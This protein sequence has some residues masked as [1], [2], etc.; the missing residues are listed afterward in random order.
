[1]NLTKYIFEEAKNKFKYMQCEN[2]RTGIESGDVYILDLASD[3][4]N[5]I[6]IMFCNGCT[7]Q[8]KSKL[9]EATNEVQTYKKG[10]YVLTVYDGF[11]KQEIG[12]YETIDEAKSVKER[13]ENYEI[14]KYGFSDLYKIEERKLM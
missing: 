12:R 10:E 5:G 8:L 13:W 6:G 4:D 9:D 11:E 2:C 7:N 14:S 1:M 3:K